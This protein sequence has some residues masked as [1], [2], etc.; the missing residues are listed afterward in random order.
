[1]PR[2]KMITLT[3][4]IEGREDDYNHWYQ[5][6]HL[7]QI[8]TYPGMKA[9]QR[10]RVERVMA[11]DDSL[12]YVAIYEIETDDVDAALAAINAGM[13][14]GALTMTEA[15]DATHSVAFICEE[16]GETVRAG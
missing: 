16:Y 5:D 2:Y 6:V 3:R 15:V 7:P 12:P 8:M 1:M 13:A 14:S 11:G 4:P 9:A 10:F